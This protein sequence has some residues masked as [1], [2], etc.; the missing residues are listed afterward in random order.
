MRG[1]TM[2]AASLTMV[3]AR[4]TCPCDVG[5]IQLEVRDWRGEP[6][7]RRGYVAGYGLLRLTTVRRYHSEDCDIW[8][9]ATVSSVVPRIESC[10]DALC[11]AS[12]AAIYRQQ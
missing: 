8:T 3:C 6:S 5:A 11:L 2:A 10:L 4:D 9:S 1:I 12:K 7:N